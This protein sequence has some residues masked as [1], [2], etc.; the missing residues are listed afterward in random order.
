MV[1]RPAPSPRLRA[2]ASS[3]TSCS[4]C[5]RR[6]TLRRSCAKRIGSSSPAACS[7][8]AVS[9]PAGPALASRRAQGGQRL[10]AARPRRLVE[11]P[12]GAADLDQACA[13]ARASSSEAGAVRC[14]ERSRRRRAALRTG[15]SP[16]LAQPGETS[17]VRVRRQ[18]LRRRI[19][20]SLLWRADSRPGWRPSGLPRRSASC[21][22]PRCRPAPEHCGRR[23]ND[24][25]ASRS[26]SRRTRSTTRLSTPVARGLPG[27]RTARSA[28]AFRNGGRRFASM[29]CLAKSRIP[30]GRTNS[31]RR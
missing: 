4:T 26:S 22:T 28:R 30:A 8:A 9:R 7:A 1:R 23:W 17:T 11:P 21:S 19:H 10:Y 16:T 15:S 29:R 3:P 12:A 6:T 24:Y 2:I 27:S 25:G 14:A 20:R 18:R 13:V 31:T 5:S